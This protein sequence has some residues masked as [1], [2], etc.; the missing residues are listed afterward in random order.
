MSI[1]TCYSI[2][3]RSFTMV[4]HQHLFDLGIA[5]MIH[6]G[7]QL[8]PPPPVP[9]PRRSVGSELI[10]HPLQ[11]VGEVAL[12]AADEGHLRAWP[13]GTRWVPGSSVGWQRVRVTTG[14][15]APIISYV[16]C[17][18]LGQLDISWYNYSKVVSWNQLINA[19]GVAEIIGAYSNNHKEL[20]IHPGNDTPPYK[21]LYRDVCKYTCI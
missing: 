15:G 10:V 8:Q 4:S 11:S 6:A 18:N 2:T 9:A 7:P 19:R 17:F 21:L 3:H 1:D 5:T 14:I 13:R 20:G 12:A 16:G